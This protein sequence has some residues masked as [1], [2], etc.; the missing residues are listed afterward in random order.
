[1]LQQIKCPSGGP[2]LWSKDQELRT[3][4]KAAETFKKQISKT[5]KRRKQQQLICAACVCMCVWVCVCLQNF[6]YNNNNNW[7]GLLV[8]TIAVAGYV[9]S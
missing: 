2:C 3:K 4:D 8:E 9:E 7:L 5:N 6:E 1:M